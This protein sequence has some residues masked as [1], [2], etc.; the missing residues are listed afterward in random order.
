MTKLILTPPALRHEL[1]D[2]YACYA[3]VIDEKQANE[4]LEMFVPD[5]LYAVG[6]QN[7]VS[8]T[9]MWWY[10]DRGQFKLKERAAYTNGYH[11]HNP[12]RM[13]HLV[14]NIRAQQLEDDIV[15]A[16]ASFVMF[17]ADRTEPANLHV[18]GRY[19]DLFHR[20][21]GELRFAEHRVVI[22]GEAVPGNM[23]VLL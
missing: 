18:V 1:E 17:A 16:Q 20:I 22:E 13:L 11:W 8:T 15:A 9:G 5:G 7:N 23:G 14:Q 4:W 12:T 21:D 19:N 2:F 6:T 10:T 3:S